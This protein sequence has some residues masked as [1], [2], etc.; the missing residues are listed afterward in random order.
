MEVEVRTLNVGSM[1]G[2]EKELADMMERKKVDMLR[3]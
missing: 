1:I 3:V 2:K